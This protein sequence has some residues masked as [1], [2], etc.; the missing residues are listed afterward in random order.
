MSFL[1]Q[2]HLQDTGMELE[3]V[4]L[5][6][7]TWNLLETDHMSNLQQVFYKSIGWD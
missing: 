5:S 3:G 1:L 4:Q 6:Q 7:D 2:R